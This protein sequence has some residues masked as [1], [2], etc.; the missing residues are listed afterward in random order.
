MV[1]GGLVAFLLLL[2]FTVDVGNWFVHK[3]H[4]QMQADAGALAAAR[5]FN[6]CPNN[7]A[8]K[9]KA[10]QYSQDV[11]NAQI[12]GTPGVQVHRLINSKTFYNQ[13][14]KPAPDDTAVGEP[15]SVGMVDVKL[16]ETDL[17]WFFK[18]VTGLLGRV[19]FINA[20]SR[21]SIF[22]KETTKGALPI[23]VP[24]VN[25][26]KATA[27]FVN[28][29]TGNVLGS[30][31]LKR[32]GSSNGLVG[33]DNAD[34]PLPVKFDTAD[35]TVGVVI[36][37]SGGTST[38][39]GEPLV[40]CYDAGGGTA[41]SGLPSKGILHVQG[42]SAAGSGAQPNPP[43]VRQATL[44]NGTCADPY[45]SSAPANCTIGVKAKV[46]FGGPANPV[47]SLGAKL[48]AKAG[49]NDYAMT[50]SSSTGTWSSSTTIP[51]VPG[52]GPVEVTLDW[53]ET[54]GA[55]AGGK[56]CKPNKNPC[57]GSFG[58]VQRAFSASEARSGPIKVAQ[59][60]ENSLPWANSLERCSSV[61]TS[62][63]HTMVVRIG[64]KGGL[65]NA[66]DNNDPVVQLR[67]TGGSQNQSLDCDPA[68]SNLR[69]ELANGCAPT[70]GVNSG[71][72]CPEPAGTTPTHC[73]PLQ[74]GAAVGQ[75]DDGLN[76]RVFGDEQAKTCTAPNHWA[77]Y[78]NLPAN[79][80]RILQVFLT[81]F[82]TFQG[83]GNES[84][85]VT[86]FATFYLTGW[87]GSPC[88]GKGDDPVPD[89]GYIVGHFI[90]Y[91]DTLNPGSG[92]T[93]CDFS[94]LGSCTAVMTR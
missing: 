22:Q 31:P 49:G 2:T 37:L 82:G 17:P 90:K 59:V 46:D 14:T 57:T 47:T 10:A 48:V 60:L 79:D 26:R 69:D 71:T 63:S 92:T 21:V 58:V 50:Y 51:L 87:D 91:I 52:A 11:H 23:A 45:F 88:Q 78:P 80:P 19:P 12:G 84:V 28:E 39:C 24:D 1:A 36:A 27:W 5:E 55:L 62:C 25:P 44:E 54:K 7:A 3:R 18:P 13:A 29:K 42:W 34:A 41:A 77:S 68:Q 30:T 40:D 20:R 65:Q 4:L 43:V 89:K 66:A 15:C 16:T 85:P 94:A 32:V 83:S 6:S 61:Q 33:W 35:D 38:K 93:P 67:V 74:T 70:Y 72:P 8:I 81:P 56:D 86:G 76:K 75:V 64:V 73:V 9:D 53:E